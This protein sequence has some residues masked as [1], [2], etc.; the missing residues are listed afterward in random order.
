MAT[1][2]MEEGRASSRGAIAQGKTSLPRRAG[3]H[4]EIA[5]LRALGPVHE[6]RRPM[7]S[8]CPSAA[9][10]LGAKGVSASEAEA[11]SG[12][13]A[14]ATSARARSRMEPIYLLCSLRSV[15]ASSFSKSVR[16]QSR[17]LQAWS[18]TGRG[19]VPFSP[20]PAS[21]SSPC[22]LVDRRPFALRGLGITSSLSR[23][24]KP[25]LMI[26]QQH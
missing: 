23:W 20:S 24:M 25:S 7:A 12:L 3:G 8:A 5:V 16:I 26:S 17:T 6:T 9:L 22:V 4:R 19:A 10:S 13:A 14:V 18:A 21:S 1:D 2:M 11:N 15:A